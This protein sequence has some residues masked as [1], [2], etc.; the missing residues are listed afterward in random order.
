MGKLTHWWWC[1]PVIPAL[2]RLRQGSHEFKANPG[3]HSKTL[4]QKTANNKQTTP[5]LKKKRITEDKTDG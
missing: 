2:S 5:P 4:S 1:T 3:F